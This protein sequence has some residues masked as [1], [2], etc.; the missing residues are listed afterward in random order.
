MERCEQQLFPRLFPLGAAQEAFRL[1]QPVFGQPHCALDRGTGGITADRVVEE[2]PGHHR[3]LRAGAAD[4][5]EKGVGMAEPDFGVLAAA[6]REEVVDFGA[7]GAAA[8]VADAAEAHDVADRRIDGGDHPFEVAGKVFGGGAVTLENAGGQQFRAVRGAPAEEFARQCFFLRGGAHHAIVDDPGFAGEVRQESA[9]A[10]AVHIV[11]GPDF[12]AE[13]FPEIRSA[14]LVVP[15][16]GFRRREIAVGLDVPAADHVETSGG[17]MAAQPLERGGIVPLD[18]LI[19]PRF[20]PGEVDFRVSVQQVAGGPGGGEGFVDALFQPPEPDR[21]EMGIED[22]VN[23]RLH[24]LCWSLVVV[25][26][27]M[28]AISSG[29]RAMP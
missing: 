29:R 26:C 14:E 7:G 2:F 16:V 24:W 17:D 19:E 1:K 10:E 23:D 13:F 6:L 4:R 27:S 20:A 25:V 3:Q 28:A 21:V 5:V 18:G 9:V 8:V 15:A 11:A 12:D 22:D